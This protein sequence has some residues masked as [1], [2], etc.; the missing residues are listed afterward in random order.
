MTGPRL[1]QDLG[2]W[3]L[4]ER[5]GEITCP[6]L[7]VHGRESIFPVSAAE[8]LARGIPNATL[9]VIDRCGHFPFRESPDA[10]AE[11]V[12]EFLRAF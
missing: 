8:T 2:D 1:R 7:V 3:D 11:S 4:T 6:T 5:L 10:F 9:R 12:L